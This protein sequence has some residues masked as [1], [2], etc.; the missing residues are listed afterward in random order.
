MGFF[1]YYYIFFENRLTFLKFI[2]QLAYDV[3]KKLFMSLSFL[4]QLCQRCKQVIFVAS[5]SYSSTTIITSS[6][7]FTKSATSSSLVLRSLFVSLLDF[8]ISPVISFSIFPILLFAV[9]FQT[10][11]T[12]TFPFKRISFPMLSIN[13]F[14]SENVLTTL[15]GVSM[16]I[17]L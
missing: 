8:N 4:R 3:T 9:R 5:F 10:C 2:K 14:I 1:D 13:C 6:S 16:K 11:S 17:L 7:L 12:Q 15:Y